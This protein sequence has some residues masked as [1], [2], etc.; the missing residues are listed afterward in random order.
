[1]TD[2]SST[3]QIDFM[4]WLIRLIAYVID[5]IIIGI[6]A[7]IIYYIALLPL[8]IPSTTYFGVT[9]TGVAPWWAFILLLPIVFG[10][11]E[12]LYFM[13]LDSAWGGTIGKRI[14]GLQVQMVKGGKVPFD[15]SIIRNISKIFWLFLI[16][17]WLIG[18]VTPGADRR[19]KLTDRWAGTTVVQIR[20][21]FQSAAPSPAPPPPPPPS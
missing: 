2:N 15:K 5:S 20:Q 9:V 18:I 1:M 12:L 7:A 8:L 6:V 4:H 17:D 3:G 11:L 21:A 19:Q 14:L 10:I 16:L 13:I